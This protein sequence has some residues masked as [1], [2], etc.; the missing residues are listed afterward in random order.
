MS[1]A[2][3]RHGA[4]LVVSHRDALVVVAPG[5]RAI[6]FEDESA[7]LV[8]VALE[9]WSEAH[10][11]AELVAHLRSLAGDCDPA[12]ISQTAGVLRDAGA[13][14]LATTPPADAR[15]SPAPIAG[16][17][18]AH[19]VVGVSGAIAAADVP[20]L[21][22]QLQARRFEVT[23][24][25]T[26]AARR[27]VARGSLASIT[28]RSVPT[29]FWRRPEEGPAPHIH[30]AA[31]ADLIVV[32]PAS[33]ATLAR[34]AHALCTDVVSAAVTAARCPVLLVPSMNE[35]MYGSPGVRRNLELLRRDG[36]HV[37][38]SGVG[39][40]VAWRPAERVA[41]LGPAPPP[42]Q[43][44][45]AVEAILADLLA[46][47]ASAPATAEAWDRQYET[48]AVRDLPWY[49]E[50]L[51]PDLAQAVR[52]A[53]P[54]RLLDVGTGLGTAAIFASR[55]GFDVVATDVSRAALARARERAGGLPI[56]WMLDD[57]T[58]TR[59]W[60]RFDV[61]VDRGCL[62]CLPPSV[63]SRYADAAARWLAPG[64]RLL[65][66]VHAPEEGGRHG[67]HPAGVD[68]LRETFAA[69]FDV[70]HVTPSVFA[71]TTDPAPKALLA[72]LVRR[73]SPE[74]P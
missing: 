57:V 48:T 73:P 11:E 23:V 65:L 6:R 14:R 62:H 16:P 37:T 50:E 34:I 55:H 61:A 67:T 74:A 54:G 47:R 8:R 70:A 69:S 28:H 25:M 46:R 4:A 52:E 17:P 18:R 63:W 27:F 10:T 39:Q 32:Y 49:T 58:D 26:A 15:S 42:S 7:E 31:S 41:T 71:G 30:L 3:I 13:L 21:V 60:G 1:S 36:R 12:L 2:W 51:D 35:A 44:V 72:V 22:R 66:K 59:L 53:A 38:L 40:E 19:V 20:S 9:F 68:E 64:G 56:A 43:I 33:A 45:T 29:G 5:G 24:A